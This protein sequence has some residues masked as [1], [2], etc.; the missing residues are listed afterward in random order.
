MADGHFTP[1]LTRAASAGATDWLIPLVFVLV[2][3]HGTNHAWVSVS[4]IGVGPSDIAMALAVLVSLPRLTRVARDGRLI[5]LLVAAFLAYA[6]L[7]WIV[8]VAGHDAYDSKKHL[9]AWAKFSEFALIVLLVPALVTRRSLRFLGWAVA[10][11]ACAA[12]LVAIVQFAGLDILGS[13]GQ[14]NRQPSFTGVH[15]LG[16][17]GGVSLALAYLGWTLDDDHDSRLLWCAALAGGVCLVMSGAVA[18]GIGLAGATAIIVLVAVRRSRATPR[19]LAIV[20]ATALVAELGVVVMRGGDIQQFAR[21]IGIEAKDHAT[22]ANVQTY[23][24][25]S[26]Q[27]YIGYR[28]WRDHPILGSGW[29]SVTEPAVFEPQLPAAHA[30]FPDQPPLAFP[31]RAHPWGIDNAYVETLAELG[32][33]GIVLLAAIL[34]AGL[35]AGVRTAL[36]APPFAAGVATLGTA[37]LLVAAGVWIG[38]GLVIAPFTDTVWLGLGLVI[39]ARELG[40]A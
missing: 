1:R 8:P 22:N 29:Q 4:S 17:L 26:L 21:Y 28:V 2:F 37:W 3:I 25:R 34:A 14:W 40:N 9:V 12:G 7:D 38:Q 6:L 24:Q 5:T 30:R 20:L 35:I 19:V 10:G 11:V 32:L 16:T 33:V 13:W 15:E 36:R 31:S 18:A 23:A 27:L 39:L